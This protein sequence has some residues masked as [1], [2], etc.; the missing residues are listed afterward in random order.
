M[1]GEPNWL[2]SYRAKKITR[3]AFSVYRS[4]ICVSEPLI[5]AVPSRNLHCSE[6]AGKNWSL[7]P[8]LTRILGR[9]PERE[10]NSLLAALPYNAL[11]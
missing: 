10:L 2:A 3:L 8:C 7:A 1:Y 9:L 11:F 5:P 4:N 6:L